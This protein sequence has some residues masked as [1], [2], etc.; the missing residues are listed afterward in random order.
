MESIVEKWPGS[1]CKRGCLQVKGFWLS[2]GDDVDVTVTLHQVC[3]SMA[4]LSF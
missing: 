1:E 2:L 3:D 4:T